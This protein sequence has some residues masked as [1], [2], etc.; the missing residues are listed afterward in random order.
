VASAY[1][2]TRENA[3]ILGPGDPGLLAVLGVLVPRHR[4]D[5]WHDPAADALAHMGGETGV[6][7]V[8]IMRPDLTS[9]GALD[10]LL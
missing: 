3:L 9:Q 1:R 5:V 2:R 4:A 6:W 10:D 7:I 8:G